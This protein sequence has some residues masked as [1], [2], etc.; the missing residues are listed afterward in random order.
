[1]RNLTVVPARQ[2]HL[3]PRAKHAPMEPHALTAK[4]AHPGHT[5]TTPWQQLKLPVN[6]I[7]SNQ[8]ND[9][10]KAPTA[11]LPSHSSALPS[12]PFFI[13][14]FCYPFFFIY[15]YII[16]GFSLPCSGPH[17]VTVCS[18]YCFLSCMFCPMCWRHFTTLHA[19]TLVRSLALQPVHLINIYLRLWCSYI[20]CIL[21]IRE[22]KLK[23]NIFKKSDIISPWS[24]V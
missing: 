16:F 12:V 17:V 4:V 15:V 11:W 3:P 20:C 14:I 18:S 21:H 10:N 2:S 6:S 5:L 9:A 8:V 23:N 22:V 7:A 13:F 24:M 19:Y 1:M